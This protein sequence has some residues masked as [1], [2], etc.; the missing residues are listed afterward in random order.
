MKLQSYGR[1]Q[2]VNHTVIALPRIA[3]AQWHQV[4]CLQR[5]LLRVQLLHRVMGN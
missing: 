4:V 3:H 5:V 1:L 2:A